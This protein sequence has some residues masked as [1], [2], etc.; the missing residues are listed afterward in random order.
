M[1]SSEFFYK[2]DL[3]ECLPH[4]VHGCTVKDGFQQITVSNKNL[5]NKIFLWK[6]QVK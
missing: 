4:V 5:L 1:V 6:S 3:I 2:A